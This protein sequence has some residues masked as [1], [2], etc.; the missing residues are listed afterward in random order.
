MPAASLPRA[1]ASAVA[2]LVALVALRMAAKGLLAR[3]WL[4]FHRQAAGVEWDALPP[5]V[6]RVLLALTRSVG[7]A[8]LVVFLI[9]AAVQVALWWR[10]D[11][12]LAAAGLAI[13]ATFCAGLGVLNRA[14]HVAT[15]AATPWKG[16]FGAAA[17]LVVAAA[18][19]VVK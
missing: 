7:L 1:V 3:E 2:L 18:A 14:L 13:G 5:G 8:F 19:A 6:Q 15:G 11:G 4:P 17:L 12:A 16:S 9:L 10:P